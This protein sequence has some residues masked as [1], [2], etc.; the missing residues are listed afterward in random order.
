MRQVAVIQALIASLKT[1]I[2]ECT[3]PNLNSLAAVAAK[4]EAE[5]CFSRSSLEDA[6]G[7]VSLQ[8]VIQLSRLEN[9]VTQTVCSHLPH[10]LGTVSR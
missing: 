10:L 2:A 4:Q 5:Q 9:L 3:A 1:K 8:Y 7:V 6:Q